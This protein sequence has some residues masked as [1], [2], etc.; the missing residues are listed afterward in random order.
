MFV[1]RKDDI[2]VFNLRSWVDGNIEGK[3]VCGVDDIFSLRYVEFAR[4]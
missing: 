4:P 3:V 1:R 2:Q